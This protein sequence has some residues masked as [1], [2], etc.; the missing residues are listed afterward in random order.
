MAWPAFRLD[1]AIAFGAIYMSG[2]FA[3]QAERT[4]PCGAAGGC[5]MVSIPLQLL[6]IQDGQLNVSEIP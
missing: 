3:F 5:E 6:A 1:P 2:F 4:I